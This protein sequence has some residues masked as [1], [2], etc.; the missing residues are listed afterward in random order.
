M[1]NIVITR[2]CETET[3]LD[4]LA[5]QINVEHGLAETAM[6]DS[7]MHA[8]RA[9]EFLRQAKAK[10]QHGAW[11]SWLRANCKVTVR[12]AQR[13]M[14]LAENWD[15]IPDKPDL[16]L[17]SALSSLVDSEETPKTPNATSSSH[18][19]PALAHYY[20]LGLINDD[21]MLLL[22]DLAGDY[23]LD[24]V[25][26]L[27]FSAANV[28]PEQTYVFLDQIR[29]EAY[30]QPYPCAILFQS[31]VAAIVDAVQIFVQDG[32]QRGDQLPQWEVTAFWHASVMV[33]YVIKGLI[34]PSRLS[35]V[36]HDRLENWRS[37]FRTALA[38]V[39]RLGQEYIHDDE[40]KR[41]WIGFGLDLAQGNI[42]I[43]AEKLREDPSAF[44]TLNKSIE[45]GIQ[46]IF[47]EMASFP[48][49][50]IYQSG[51]VKVTDD[52]IWPPSEPD[53]NSKLGEG[54]K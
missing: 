36:L 17:H 11:L 52:L 9:G 14:R 34:T 33:H 45:A 40:H 53:V 22:T 15:E 1:Q 39:G 49:P 6:H 26:H 3:S 30:P 31:P 13:Y 43:A 24:V 2:P 8:R 54:E 32:M 21:A 35:T 19:P 38:F 41:V 37:L 27:P 28:A 48:L 20:D 47:D 10:I 50:T 44:P 25:T 7:L 5:G 42:L 29:P 4:D 51:A 16:G 23:G 12:T 46:S 18:L